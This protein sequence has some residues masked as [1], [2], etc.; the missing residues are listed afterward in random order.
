MPTTQIAF[1]ERLWPSVA[2][3]ALVPGAA[4]GLFLIGLA[5]S[6][7][8]GVGAAL[9]A[10][11]LTA[12]LLVATTP[13]V[14]VRDGEL[15]AGRARIPVRLLGPAVRLDP[16]AMRR[17]RGV[18]LDARAFLCLRGWLAEGVTVPVVDPAGRTP[19]W[20]ISSRHPDALVAAL[21]QGDG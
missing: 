18:D 10:A 3:W 14:Q 21:A 1:S 20:L 17:A 6:P 11:G 12:V 2:I 9:V 5:I 8:A 7:A 4:L 19:Y 16:A 15:L 13:L